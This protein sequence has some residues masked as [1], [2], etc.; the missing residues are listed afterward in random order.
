MSRCRIRPDVPRPDPSLVRRLQQLP[1]ATVSDQLD[2]FG[3][4]TGIHPL[5]GMD[6]TARLA[7]PALTVR[8]RPG[9]N[10]GVHVAIDLAEPGDVLVV[11]GGGHVDRALVGEIVYRYAV[12]KGIAGLVVDGA[13]RDARDIAAGPV[14]VFARGT[15]HLGPDKNGPS[16]VRGPIAV[17]GTVV[18][19]GDVVLGDHDGLVA[20]PADRLD[21]VVHGGEQQA[22]QE[23]QR[24][25]SAEKGDLDRSWLTGLAEYL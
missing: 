17:G 13:V 10:L 19:S 15:I 14:P 20:V 8:T 25:A 11:D 7:G 4:L 22:E 6:L 24:L 3:A 16:E 23:V 1:T 18:H 5:P 2:K 12:A 21:E 9:D